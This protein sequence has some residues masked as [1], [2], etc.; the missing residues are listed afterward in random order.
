MD[1]FVAARRGVAEVAKKFY[2]RRKKNKD[3]P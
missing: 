2:F 1:E 3:H